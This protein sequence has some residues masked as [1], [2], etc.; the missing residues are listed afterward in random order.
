MK[1]LFAIFVILSSGILA[2]QAS[3]RHSV[4]HLN[5][6]RIGN[7]FAGGQLVSGKPGLIQLFQLR[8]HIPVAKVPKG[9]GA[10]RHRF[11]NGGFSMPK[12][13]QN[14]EIWARAYYY[15]QSHGRLN[16]VQ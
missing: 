6:V 14:G 11:G 5:Q 2:G 10:G 9:M 4:R 15:F 3:H 8:G 7:C 13:G 12:V 16:A 1:K